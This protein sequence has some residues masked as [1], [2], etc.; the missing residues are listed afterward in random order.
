MYPLLMAFHCYQDKLSSIVAC[1]VLGDLASPCLSCSLI[2]YHFPLTLLCSFIKLL[3][4]LKHEM[5]SLVLGLVNLNIFCLE[6]FC[7]PP[8]NSAVLGQMYLS[9]LCSHNPFPFT[10][11][12]HPPLY[13]P[14][15]LSLSIES[16]GCSIIPIA[17]SKRSTQILVFKYHSPAIGTRAFWKNG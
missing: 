4:F 2:F 11:T 9:L 6:Q 8:H 1:L 14:V 15:H 17:T 3:Y 5:F 10:S 7:S 16:P 12:H 13:L